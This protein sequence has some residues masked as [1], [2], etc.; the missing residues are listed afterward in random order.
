MPKGPYP[1]PPRVAEVRCTG[2]E[3][4]E[5]ALCLARLDRVPTD[6]RKLCGCR[7]VDWEG[8]RRCRRALERVPAGVEVKS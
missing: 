3:P 2:V 8:A 7:H 6:W 1:E 5:Y 4:A